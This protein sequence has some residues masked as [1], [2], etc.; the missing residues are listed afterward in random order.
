[1]TKLSDFPVLFLG[2]N[3]VLSGLAVVLITNYMGVPLL[4]L[5]GGNVIGE[6]MSCGILVSSRMFVT[7]HALSVN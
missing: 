1:M 5:E 6:A 2:L 7:Q 4:P 3:R